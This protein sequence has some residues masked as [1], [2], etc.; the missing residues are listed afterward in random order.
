MSRNTGIGNWNSV[1]FIHA[2]LLTNKKQINLC[3]INQINIRE[4]IHAF[5]TRVDATIQLQEHS[6]Y[7]LISVNENYDESCFFLC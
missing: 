7:E 6:V 2:H 3:W 5:Q 1:S 4:G